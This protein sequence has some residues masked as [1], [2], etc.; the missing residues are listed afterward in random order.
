MCAREFVSGELATS[1]VYTTS[2]GYSSVLHVPNASQRL[3]L[4]Q[5]MIKLFMQLLA[6]YMYRLRAC[7]RCRKA[8]QFPSGIPRVCKALVVY[9]ET[10][11]AGR[12][13]DPAAFKSFQ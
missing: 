13:P 9:P 3:A 10:C 7:D 4:R 1:S 12:A 6:C 11:L 2:R 8:N 5:Y